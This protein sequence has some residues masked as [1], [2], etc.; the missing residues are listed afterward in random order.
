VAKSEPGSPS[1]ELGFIDEAARD[2]PV[3]YGS[4]EYKC[5]S[6]E[7]SIPTRKQIRLAKPAKY[8]HALNDILKCPYCFFLFSP[9]SKATVLRQ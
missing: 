3:P 1:S 2:V 9:R 7:Q 8:E 4:A 5:P 6:C